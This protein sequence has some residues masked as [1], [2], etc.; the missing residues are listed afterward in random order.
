MPSRASD[1]D[2]FD[3]ALAYTT[4]PDK[5]FVTSDQPLAMRGNALDQVTAWEQP[6]T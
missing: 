1:W 6:S 3:W 2:N 5:P 4:D